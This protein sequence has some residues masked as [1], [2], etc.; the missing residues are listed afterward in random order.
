MTYTKEVCS[1]ANSIIA[2]KENEE[3]LLVG[4]G[5]AAIQALTNEI[6]M[7]LNGV[8][9]EKTD[10]LKGD[11]LVIVAI[12]TAFQENIMHAERILDLIKTQNVC[13]VAICPH[14]DNEDIPAESK[15][16]SLSS[17]ADAVIVVKKDIVYEEV[18]EFLLQLYL[19]E[20]NIQER[21]DIISRFSNSGFA[22]Y[23]YHYSDDEWDIG[24]FAS[25]A[26]FDTMFYCPLYAAEN[27]ICM[28]AYGTA[29]KLKEN[30]SDIGDD[31]IIFSYIEDYMNQEAKL[32][33]FLFQPKKYAPYT[34]GLQILA[35]G[36]GND[37]II[38]DDLGCKQ[39][40]EFR[41]ARLEN[42]V[43]RLLKTPFHNKKKLKEYEEYKEEQGV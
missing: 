32:K 34:V 10:K 8:E 24:S 40:P 39:Y 23:N 30:D 11:S 20:S 35:L 28:L 29:F 36:F 9:F 33:R 16:R 43:N 37:K 41:S 15:L 3:V 5:D 1:Q 21:K 27:V 25:F 18:I 17:R 2:R 14:C 19:N 6:N 22:Y 4:I 12:D 38:I 7:V 13:T 42:R 31:E 26:V